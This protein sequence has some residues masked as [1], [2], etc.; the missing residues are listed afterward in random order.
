MINTKGYVLLFVLMILF[1]LGFISVQL[2]ELF[3]RQYKQLNYTQNRAAII[4]HLKNTLKT[5]T[6]NKSIDPSC[7]IPSTFPDVLVN[8]PLKWWRSHAC[9]ISNSIGSI[10]YTIENL[11]T[12]PC[13]YFSHDNA[14]HFARFVRYTIAYMTS[15]TDQ[16]PIFIQSVKLN[17]S[18][19]DAS[20]TQ[21]LLQAEEGVQMMR[22]I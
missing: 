10:Y 22:Q 9:L 21:S 3:N 1:L 12:H 14:P 18:N 2:S 20:C 17:K 13:V 19:E 15:A 5:V 6:T 11:A 8:Y 7:I 4:D 16:M